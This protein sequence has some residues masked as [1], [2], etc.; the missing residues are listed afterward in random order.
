V[1]RAWSV[2]IA[3]VLKRSHTETAARL[4]RAERFSQVNVETN[5]HGAHGSNAD[6]SPLLD[7]LDDS[8]K[9]LAWGIDCGG[10]CIS[11]NVGAAAL[12]GGPEK[13]DHT[14]GDQFVHPDD[15][16]QITPLRQCSQSAGAEYRVEYRIVLSDWMRSEKASMTSCIRMMRLSCSMPFWS[17]RKVCVVLECRIDN[18]GNLAWER[19]A[20]PPVRSS[21]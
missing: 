6:L 13:F 7:E 12:F 11:L 15:L 2:C 5:A 20:I 19:C 3:V 17:S 8:L 16:A 18:F 4:V 9:P 1:G 10:A 14:A 21:A